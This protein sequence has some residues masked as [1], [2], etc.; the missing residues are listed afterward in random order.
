MSKIRLGTEPK[1][2]I[3]RN[4]IQFDFR[5]VQHENPKLQGKTPV[6]LYTRDPLTRDMKPKK[7]WWHNG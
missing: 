5:D 2:N 7:K 6:V 4:N 1:N 3:K